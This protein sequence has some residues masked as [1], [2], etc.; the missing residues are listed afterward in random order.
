MVKACK[1][2]EIAGELEVTLS[3]YNDDFDPDLL[4]LQLQIFGTHYKQ[5]QENKSDNSRLTIFDV[6]NYFSSI[7]LGQRLLL[8][9][10][11]KL[12]KLV[13]VMPATT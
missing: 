2:E 12:L 3:L 13:L 11:E 1:Q 5:M 7:S 10:V 4:K 6:K 9:Q 8:S